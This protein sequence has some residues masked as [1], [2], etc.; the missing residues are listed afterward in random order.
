M[1]LNFGFQRSASLEP[2]LLSK[3]QFVASTNAQTEFVIWIFARRDS[4]LPVR[5][6]SSR[7]FLL[8]GSLKSFWKSEICWKVFLQTS[9]DDPKRFSIWALPLGRANFA[10]KIDCFFFSEKILA[11]KFFIYHRQWNSSAI[12]IWNF[13]R[14]N[15]S[16][17]FDVAFS[18]IE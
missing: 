3:K 4:E 18:N 6:V 7:K 1:L 2:E 15:R 12:F 14:M 17:S 5:S 11:T 13:R 8:F 9:S 10:W 16:S